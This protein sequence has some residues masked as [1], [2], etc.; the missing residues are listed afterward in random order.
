[1]LN[2]LLLFRELSSGIWCSVAL[3][4][5]IDV[6]EKPAASISCIPKMLVHIYQSTRCHIQKTEILILNTK[7]TSVRFGLLSSVSFSLDTSIVSFHIKD[8]FISALYLY[9]CFFFPFFLSFFIPSVLPSYFSVSF[10]L[11]ISLFVPPLHLSHFF[12]F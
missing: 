4:I 12:P 1:M 9:L 5:L 7:R 8:S 2:I 11:G 3:Y 10:L 6:S